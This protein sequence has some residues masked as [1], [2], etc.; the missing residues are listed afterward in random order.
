MISATEARKG[1]TIEL[2]GQL[3]RVVDYSH[4]KMGRGSAQVRLKLRDIRS[5]HTVERAFQST[6]KLTPARLESRHAQYLYRE[7]DL[8]YFMDTDTF[9][10][11]TLGMAQMEG[12]TEYLKEDMP[13]EISVYKDKPLGVQLPVTVEL[14]V[15]ETGPA[16]KGDTATAGTKPATMETGLKVQ[17]PMFTKV[18]DLLKID[19]RTGEYL[20]RAG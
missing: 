19:T 6:E 16:F 5:G 11:F 1:V 9:E 12:V 13:I 18:G 17:V 2:D 3:Y 7:D 20:E 8:F 10:Q 14:R 4:I 15:A